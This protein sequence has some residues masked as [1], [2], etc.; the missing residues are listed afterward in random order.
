MFDKKCDFFFEKINFEIN[1]FIAVTR[2][3]LL[4]T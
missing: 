4:L 1:V 3:L 2:L